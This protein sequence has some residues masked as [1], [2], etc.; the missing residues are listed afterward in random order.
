MGARISTRSRGRTSG[1]KSLTDEVL[2]VVLLAAAVLLMISFVTYDPWD[3]SWNSVGTKQTPSNGIGVVGA[4]AGDIFFH[5]FGLASFALPALLILIAARLFFSNR[6]QLPARKIAG[7]SLLIVTLAGLLALLPKLG[8][9]KLENTVSNGGMVGYLIEGQLASLMNIGGAAIVLAVATVLT[10]M[11]TLEVSLASIA[12]RLRSPRDVRA[13]TRAARPSVLSRLRGWW[14]VRWER[15]RQLVRE[16]RAERLE[17][18]RQKNEEREL[19]RAEELARVEE[20]RRQRAEEVR[21]WEQQQEVAGTVVVS[22]Q[23][24][25]EADLPRMPEVVPRK[26]PVVE[27]RE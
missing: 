6:L 16:R 3:P 14:A 18:K 13:D 10:L 15:R 1:N 9:Y 2:A 4:Y 12:R 8:L 19:R 25:V 11:L 24:A 20:E 27:R 26:S 7:A 23:E 17:L 21:R 22:G 5:L